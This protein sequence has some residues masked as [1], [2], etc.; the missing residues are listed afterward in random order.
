MKNGLTLEALQSTLAR[1]RR[2]RDHYAELSESEAED[3][4]FSSCNVVNGT[5][6]MILAAERLIEKETFTPGYSEDASPYL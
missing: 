6:M 5:E 3:A 2:E 4:F 1:L